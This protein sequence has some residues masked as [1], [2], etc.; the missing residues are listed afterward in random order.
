[1]V[2]MGQKD[3][4]VDDEAQSK[5]GEADT[6]TSVSWL[7]WVKKMPTSVVRPSQREVR[8]TD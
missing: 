6:D 4:Y 8:Q 5:R 1:M 3:A 2:G 7:V